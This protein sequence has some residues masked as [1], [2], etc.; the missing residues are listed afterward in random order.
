[1]R[2]DLVM[3][4]KRSLSRYV[5]TGDGR[6][7][8]ADVWLAEVIHNVPPTYR[9]QSIGR[10]P[11]YPTSI[12]TLSICRLAIYRISARGRKIRGTSCGGTSDGG[13]AEDAFG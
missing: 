13:V 7:V 1:M 12:S 10:F 8:M 3:V 2:G 9:H 4:A 11:I 5:L 6:G